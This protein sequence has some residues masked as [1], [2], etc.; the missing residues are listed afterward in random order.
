M[1]SRLLNGLTLVVIGIILL[2]NT[3][4][5]LPWDVWGA[6]LTYWPVLL[7]GLGVQI[8]LSRWKIPGLSLAIIAILILGAMNPYA[9]NGVFQRSWQFRLFPTMQL[10]VSEKDWSLD[11]EPAVSKLELNCEAPGMD[12]EVAG[13]PDLNDIDPP[14]ALQGK[15]RWDKYGPVVTEVSSGDT[16]KATLK[17][18]VPVDTSQA[19]TQEWVLAVNSSLTTRLNLTGGVANLKLDASRL[20]VENVVLSAGVTSLDLNLGLSGKKTGVLVTGGVGN[21]KVVVPASAGVRI[22]ISGGL[23]SRD[24]SKQG[25]EKSGDVWITPGY[26]SATTKLDLTVSC[27]VGKVS[28]IRKDTAF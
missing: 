27:G 26:D 12:V 13:L 11:L 23:I 9:N 22:D 18:S 15:L 21:V 20:Y 6:A 14:G 24:F 16:L 7:I 28:L 3:T 2:M 19:G 25:L 8:A 4:G 1:V 17:S 5:S 10:E